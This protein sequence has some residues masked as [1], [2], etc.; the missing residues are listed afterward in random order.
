MGPHQ[1]LSRRPGVRD[2]PET[3]SLNGIAQSVLAYLANL[4]SD[5]QAQLDA[6]TAAAQALAARVTTAESGLTTLVG[7][8]LRWSF[9]GPTDSPRPR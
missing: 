2:G 9:D 5:A 1:H 3:A 7:R 8:L 4:R 6:I